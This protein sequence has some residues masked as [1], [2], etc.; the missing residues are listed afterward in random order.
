MSFILAPRHLSQVRVKLRS[1]CLQNSY[2]R[3]NTLEMC[4]L[5]CREPLCPFAAGVTVDA[6]WE[7]TVCLMTPLRIDL[8]IKMG[9]QSVYGSKPISSSSTYLPS[10]VCPVLPHQHC[11]FLPPL[12]PLFLPHAHHDLKTV[13]S[14]HCRFACLSPILEYVFLEFL[15]AASLFSVCHLCPW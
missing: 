7:G 11:R 13:V 3:F 2:P 6:A 15:K 5:R 14:C 10:S 9:S 12:C 8:E 4:W 1:A